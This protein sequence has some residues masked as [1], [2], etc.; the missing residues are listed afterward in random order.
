MALAKDL[1]TSFTIFTIISCLIF[2]ILVSPSNPT[3]IVF[4]DYFFNLWSY[5]NSSIL[6]IAC[7]SLGGCSLFI[8]PSLFAL[9]LC[10]TSCCSPGRVTGSSSGIWQNES[11]PASSAP[12][13]KRH[14][15]SP[16]AILRAYDP[17]RG[18]HAPGNHCASRLSPRMM[19]GKAHLNLSWKPGVRCDPTSPNQ[20]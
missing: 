9:K 4:F 17:S 18:N 20:G 14:H 16:L 15:V 19:T 5:Q 2:W 12:K 6:C 8:T 7:G 10:S 13:P 3:S 1:I 11:V